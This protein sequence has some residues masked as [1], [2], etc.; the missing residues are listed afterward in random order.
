MRSPAT[1]LMCY[2]ENILGASVIAIYISNSANAIFF[3]PGTDCDKSEAVCYHSASLLD[4][5]IL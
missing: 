1:I 3:Y 2:N 4:M 5:G